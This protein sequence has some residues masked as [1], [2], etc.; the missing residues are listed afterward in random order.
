MTEKLK[1]EVGEEDRGDSKGLE[2]GKGGGREKKK[3]SLERNR[4]ER[5]MEWKNGEGEE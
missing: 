2:S 3:R 4:N 5:F 1:A